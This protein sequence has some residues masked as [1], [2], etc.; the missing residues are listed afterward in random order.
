[1][2]TS[3]HIGRSIEIARNYL[4]EH[5]EA[6]R[7]TDSAASAVVEDGLRC[8]VESPDG[9][10]IYTD[11][12]TGVGGESTAPS[13]GWFSRAG[14]ASCE[15]TLITMRAAELGIPLQRVKVVVD[16]ESDGRGILA[17][18][19]EV[20]AGPLSLRTRVRITADGIDPQILLELVE[21]ADR[22]SPIADAVRR[23]VPVSVDVESAARELS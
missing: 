4:A 13:P 3:S 16:S 14:H 8:R 5:P 6:A 20:P 18:D 23:A 7:Y 9:T 12:P 15:A 17:M 2:T 22:Y 11:M 1:M 21:S 10:T 19:D